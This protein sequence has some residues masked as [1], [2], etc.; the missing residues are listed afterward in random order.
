MP[1]MIN[2]FSRSWS[3]SAYSFLRRERQTK[4]EADSDAKSHWKKWITCKTSVCWC[5]FSHTTYTCTWDIYYK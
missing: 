1:I 5:N 4:T 3:G 2:K